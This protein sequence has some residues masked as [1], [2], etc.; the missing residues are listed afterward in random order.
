MKSWFFV[1]DD[2]QVAM[3]LASIPRVQLPDPP[4]SDIPQESSPGR[5]ISAEVHHPIIV[6]YFVG[7]S[8]STSPQAVIREHSDAINR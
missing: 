1:L 4:S 7:Y 3:L 2:T 6:L 5:I 8:R